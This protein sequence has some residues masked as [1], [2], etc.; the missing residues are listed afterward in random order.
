LFCF[1]QNVENLESCEPVKRQK[2]SISNERQEKEQTPNPVPDDDVEEIIDVR[3][4]EEP[5]GTID[6][7]EDDYGL[8]SEGTIFYFNSG[9]VDSRHER[10]HSSRK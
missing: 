1:R 10:F 2:V 4:M 8:Q 7:Q 3:E 6:D 5:E 9:F